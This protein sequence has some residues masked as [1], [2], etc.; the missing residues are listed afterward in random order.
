M[1]QRSF[2]V[3]QKDPINHFCDIVRPVK[4]DVT[5]V[6]EFKSSCYI[7]CVLFLCI[8]YPVPGAARLSRAPFS[9]FSR[10]TSV[11]G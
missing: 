2:H 5:R 9:F 7:E 4:H 8:S 1:L 6:R 3:K 10:E 11:T